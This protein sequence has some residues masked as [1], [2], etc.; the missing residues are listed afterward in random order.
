M[1]INTL[2]NNL[3]VWTE[4]LDLIEQG[5]S[6]L[7]ASG[8]DFGSGTSVAPAAPVVSK[9]KTT[10]RP[11]PSPSGARKSIVHPNQIDKIVLDCMLQMPDQ[12]QVR[13]AEVVKA[14]DGQVT[15]SDVDKSIKFFKESGY[16][17]TE[18]KG[19]GTFYVM[20]VTSN[21][22]VPQDMNAS[23]TKTYRR[24]DGPTVIQMVRAVMNGLPAN[25]KVS[26]AQLKAITK[27]T[28]PEANLVDS[29]F[30][31]VFSQM[32][33]DGEI[34]YEGK[35]KARVY[36]RGDD[37][38]ENA[39]PMSESE[40]ESTEAEETEN[41]AETFDSDFEGGEEAEA[42]EDELPEEEDP[43]TEAYD[44]ETEVVDSEEYDTL[45]AAAK[46]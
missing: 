26:P 42:S 6:K 11:T 41:E 44:E 25:E 5:L 13:K 18:G 40:E 19:R 10:V 16:I 30:G 24:N 45:P 36:W 8:F 2:K 46:A 27:D 22:I 15:A 37:K 29:S 28:F 23:D 32:A 1:D 33:K 7:E 14:L 3:P 9:P 38:L 20:K 31:T 35:G 34:S 12:T 39:A 43:E 17:E 21:T 4:A